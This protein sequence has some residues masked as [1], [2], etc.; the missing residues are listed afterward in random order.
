MNL[1]EIRKDTD[2]VYKTPP[3]DQAIEAFEDEIG[4]GPIL[5]PMQLC[6]N[7]PVTHCWNTDLAE[8]FIQRFMHQHEIEQSEEA[9]LVELFT[10]RFGSLK[11]RYNEWQ[12]GEGEDTVQRT[13]RVKEKHGRGR[14]I[15]RKDTRRNKVSKL[16]F[17]I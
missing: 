9:L 5:K 12:I 3:T 10:N 16:R 14:K 4:E 13:Q 1:L 15:Q 6:F 2:I 7:V 8:Q 11:R 17:D